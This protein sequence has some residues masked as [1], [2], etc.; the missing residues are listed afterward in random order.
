MSSLSAWCERLV[1]RSYAYLSVIYNISLLLLLSQYKW[2]LSSN[3]TLLGAVYTY[4]H[5]LHQ[6]YI[7]WVETDH[8]MAGMGSVTN[9]PV[10]QSVSI[11]TM[12]NFEGD[13]HGQGDGTCKQA[14]M[15]KCSFCTESDTN[16]GHFHGVAF[17]QCESTIR[18]YDGTRTFC[19]SCIWCFCSSVRSSA[20]VTFLA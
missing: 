2:V 19:C 17:G 4:F 5:R 16:T 20:P 18:S 3:N 6:I 9:L 8:L 1:I 15:H 10:K 14:F 12:L 11:D 13:G 7:A